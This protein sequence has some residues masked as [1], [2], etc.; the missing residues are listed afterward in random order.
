MLVLWSYLLCPKICWHN[1][2]K[3]IYNAVYGLNVLLKSV[4]TTLLE[5]TNLHCV[6]AVQD[7]LKLD[8]H[9]RTH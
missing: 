2:R 1:R 4:L 3:P 6:A 7:H 9:K 5:Y 8:E